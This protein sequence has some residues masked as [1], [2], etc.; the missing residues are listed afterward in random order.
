MAQTKTNDETIWFRIP[1]V[2]GVI[3]ATYKLHGRPEHEAE[4][5][6]QIPTG[7]YFW[8]TANVPLRAPLERWLV[9]RAREVKHHRD[10]WLARQPK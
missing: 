10:R 6:I 9:D 3:Y 4:F 5:R 1:E 7:G 8:M 2:M